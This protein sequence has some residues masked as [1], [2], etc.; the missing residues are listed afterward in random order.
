MQLSDKIYVAGHRG[1]LGSALVR[2]L[3][4]AGYGNLLLPSR[5][6]LDL[7]DAGAVE[8]FFCENR[9]R[10]VFLAAAK[11]GG[12]LA[13]QTF[14]AEFILENLRIQTNVIHES[15]RSGVERLLVLGSS[16][17][18]P[19]LAPQPLR[20]ESFLAGPL[21]ST[22][23]AYAV[24]KIAGIEMAW[25]YNRQYGTRFLAAMPTNLYGPG[26]HYDP[27][28]SHLVP[29][30]I[31]KMHEA[32]VRGRREVLLWGSGTPRRE[33]LHSDDA[34]EACIFLMRLA[35]EAFDRLASRGQD[36]VSPL[37]NIGCGE[38]RTVRE[39][40]ELVA[41][42]VGV[43]PTLVFDSS[44]PDGTP[45]KLLDTSRLAALGWKARIGLREGIEETYADF[46]QQLKDR[47]RA[48]AASAK[49]DSTKP[50]TQCVS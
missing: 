29:A 18:Y 44:K 8:Q 15:W 30:L 41:E 49:P 4:S 20:E 43:R 11:V 36:E 16:C 9:P 3:R 14:P 22:N 46:R 2:G 34:A 21:E 47:D 12:I 10:Y 48:G 17:I 39:L 27:Q 28:S 6:E 7:T 42:V 38:D 25:S 26:D 37:V 13:N 45:R 1:L 35:P 40:A 5:R 31:R 24:A 33:F 32:K 19:R 23:R 50:V